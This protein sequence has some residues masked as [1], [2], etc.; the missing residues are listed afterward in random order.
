MALRNFPLVAKRF[1][2][3]MNKKVHLKCYITQHITYEL[4]KEKKLN[5]IQRLGCVITLKYISATNVALFS[6]YH[7]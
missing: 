6:Q 4:Y 7:N 2:D 3:S 1:V 5:Q